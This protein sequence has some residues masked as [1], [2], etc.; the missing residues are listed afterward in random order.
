MGECQTMGM[1]HEAALRLGVVEGVTNDGMAVMS[2][3][4]TDLVSTSCFQ[5]AFD[6]S[7]VAKLL[8]SGH[9]SFGVEPLF[10]INKAF[11]SIMAISADFIF[12]DD[13]L[14]RKF[15]LGKGPIFAGDVFV[16]QEAVENGEDKGVFGEKDGTAGFFVQAVNDIAGLSDIA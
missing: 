13:S 1:E 2:E 11:P 7:C 15:P 9:M 6:Q 16:F 10:R 4:D 14:I 5:L 3:M 12:V 8:E